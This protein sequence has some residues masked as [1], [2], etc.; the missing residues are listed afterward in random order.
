MAL[1]Y[2]FVKL[3]YF[4]Q[5]Q[6]LNFLIKIKSSKQTL[7]SRKHELFEHSVGFHLNFFIIEIIVPEN[8]N[9]T[10]RLRKNIFRKDM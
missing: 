1:V 2:L 4:K 3:F 9:V 6:I 7:T 10:P 8:A 5:K